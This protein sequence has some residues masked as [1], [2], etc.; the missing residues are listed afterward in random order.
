MCN[1]CFRFTMKATPACTRCAYEAS[2]RPQ[3]RV[4]LAVSFLGFAG[5][6]AFWAVRRHDAWTAHPALLVAGAVV[7]LVVSGLLLASARGPAGRTVASRDPDDDAPIEAPFEGGAHPYRAQARRVLLAVSPRVSGKLTALIVGASLVASAVLLPASVHLPRWIEAE[8]VLSLWWLILGATL[9]VLL[10]RG[11]RLQ[12]NLV[13]FAPWDRPSSPAGGPA[14]ALEPA[15]PRRGG[16]TW[17]DGCNPGLG[18]GCGSIDGEGC[19]GAVVVL[20]LLGVAL[21][22]AWVLV[23]LAMPLA[24]FVIYALLM[25]AI[26]RAAS[27]RQGCAGH[28]GRALAWGVLWATVYVVP[29]A[30]LAWGLHEELG[31][32]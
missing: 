9:V 8:V 30:V 20:V 14:A 24:L 15:R 16:L 27:D 18:D 19:I 23:E 5:A 32:K 10:Y 31:P 17:A 3:R 21:G 13:Y 2:T 12:D 25:R 29:L 22:A 26:R 11:F 4:S 7:A 6:I 1:R 28:L